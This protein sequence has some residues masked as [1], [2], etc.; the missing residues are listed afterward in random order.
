MDYPWK[1]NGYGVKWIEDAPF[2][3][4]DKEK[5]LSGNAQRLLKMD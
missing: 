3:K 4:E 5:I 2:S 1:N